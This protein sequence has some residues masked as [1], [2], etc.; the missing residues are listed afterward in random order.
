[1]IA[2]AQM[3]AV[4][5]DIRDTIRVITAR[6]D[7]ASTSQ[8]PP[9]PQLHAELRSDLVALGQKRANLDAILAELSN[10]H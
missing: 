3:L 6:T 1:M 2:T 8:R 9:S 10:G 7:S 4:L 5:H